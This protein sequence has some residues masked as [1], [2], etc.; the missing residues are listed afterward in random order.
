MTDI[1]IDRSISVQLRIFQEIYRVFILIGL[2]IIIYIT[3]GF[4]DNI[5]EDLQAWSINLL[6]NIIV[7]V[8]LKRRKKWVPV[9][10]WIISAFAIFNAFVQTIS[11]AQE[12]E[13]LLYKILYFLL[14][15]FGAYQMYFFSRK[16]VKKIFE[17]KGHVLY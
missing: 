1:A 6:I 7:Y 16:D 9:V 2:L 12:L 8:G 11:P 4:S 14:F 15:M 5:Y 10:I 3:I 17:L 13:A